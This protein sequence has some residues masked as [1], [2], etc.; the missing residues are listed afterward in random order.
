MATALSC[1]GTLSTGA[2]GEPLCSTTWEYVIVGEY[3]TVTD[4][5]DL[6]PILMLLFVSAWG[7]KMLLRIISKRETGF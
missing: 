3:M 6:V 2:S 5:T 1:A 4:F 7:V